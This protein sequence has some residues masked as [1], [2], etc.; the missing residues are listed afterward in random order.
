MRAAET[1]KGKVLIVSFLFPPD[2]SIGA[3]RGGKMAKYLPQFGW[4]PIVLAEEL[5]GAPKTLP[6]E[7]NE[8]NVF[9]TTCPKIV[10]SLYRKLFGK[11]YGVA[12]QPSSGNLSLRSAAYR[13]LKLIPAF[14]YWPICQTL[15]SNPICWHFHASKVAAQILSRHHI[16][17][18]F[19]SYSPS[20]SHFVASKLQ[21]KTGVPWVAE[22]RDR[23]S[24][25]TYATKPLR[26]LDKWAERRLLKNSCLLITVSQDWAAQL[27]EMH[28][29]KVAVIPNGFDEE[30]YLEHVP[31]LSKFT[32]TY[33][34]GILYAGKRDPTPLFEA[35]KQLLE[36]GRL[37][38]D[39]FELRFF[40]GSSLSILFSLIKDYHLEGIVKIYNMVPFKES[41]KRQK[42]STILLL[43]SWNDPRDK[44][45]YTGKV[46]EYL[47]AQ[48]P[49]LA[50]AY[51]G[52]A[53]DRLLQESGTGILINEVGM[54]KRV[55][56]HWL[57]EW[58][59]S[60]RIVSYWEPDTNVVKRYTRKEAARKLADLLNEASSL[61]IQK[62]H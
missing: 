60:G 33:T 54:I 14:Y 25:S 42:E 28:S 12:S 30:D 43:L 29:K 8:T 18:I 3:V 49:I 7:M 35:L 23:W 5:E 58:H 59:G 39:N 16:D 47:G 36:E 44:G 20:T 40:G 2:N 61:G 41:I 52:G 19:S 56:Q 51:K 26:F 31:L 9:R 10:S 6:L 32:I 15:V 27:Q 53:I 38:P 62:T 22:F 21:Q 17:V 11:G 57:E 24:L 1:R 4:E 45:T 48:R 46:Y 13:L 50:I 55:L 34:G 37:S